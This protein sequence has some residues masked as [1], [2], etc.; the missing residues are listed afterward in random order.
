VRR[1]P[2]AE[3]NVDPVLHPVPDPVVQLNVG[4]DVRVLLAELLQEWPKDA[5]ESRPWANDT[6]RPCD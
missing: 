5:L 6:Q 3:A 2:E 4:N 1:Y